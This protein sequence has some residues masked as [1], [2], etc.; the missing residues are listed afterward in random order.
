LKKNNSADVQRNRAEVL[1]KA[2]HYRRPGARLYQNPVRDLAALVVIEE[3]GVLE[4]FL[5]IGSTGR[6]RRAH[7]MYFFFKMF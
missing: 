7:A 2:E 4:D 6:N 1:V 5:D 3:R